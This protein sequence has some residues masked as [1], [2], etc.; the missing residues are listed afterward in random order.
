[1]PPYGGILDNGLE[2]SQVPRPTVSWGTWLVGGWLRKLYDSIL[3]KGCRNG[4]RRWI[5]P[6]TKCECPSHRTM[7]NAS[8]LCQMWSQSNEAWDQHW[9]DWLEKFACNW[10]GAS[11]QFCIEHI[12]CPANLTKFSQKRS[13][14]WTCIFQACCL[15]VLLFEHFDC[16][17]IW[18]LCY[19]IERIFSTRTNFKTWESSIEKCLFKRYFRLQAKYSDILPVDLT[20][21][22][23]RVIE[24][25]D[26]GQ[27]L[28]P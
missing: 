9:K 14:R 17:L 21:M 13:I 16:A 7:Q 19:Q 6:I 11:G 18:A 5:L 28:A 25:V 1:M 27:L 23:M 4:T 8:G 10:D 3:L 22:V 2:G 26:S 24:I 20:G 15:F 12:T